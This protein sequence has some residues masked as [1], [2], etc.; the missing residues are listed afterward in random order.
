[1]G[2]IYAAAGIMPKLLVLCDPK[3]EILQSEAARYGYQEC[4][5]DWKEVVGDKRIEVFDNCGPDPAHVEPC[6]AA[7]AAGKHVICEKPLA[8]AVADAR[9]MR[10]AAAAATGK[11][12]CTFNYRFF[13]SVRLAKDGRNRQPGTKWAR[14]MWLDKHDCGCKCRKQTRLFASRSRC[15]CVGYG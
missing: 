10:D 6:I 8:V 13:P 9:R 15:E 14:C 1:M 3:E 2:Y 7:L 4:T 12:M 5:T 11:S